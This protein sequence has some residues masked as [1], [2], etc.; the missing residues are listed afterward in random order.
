MFLGPVLGPWVCFDDYLG[1]DKSTFLSCARVQQYVHGGI[2]RGGVEDQV[3]TGSSRLA[4]WG[5]GAPA[6]GRPRA[7]PPVPFARG[8]RYTDRLQL[9]DARRSSQEGLAAEGLH[10][11][12]MYMNISHMCSS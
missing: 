1:G 12:C 7:R 9:Y 2:V 6:D 8:A 5:T 11:M 10:P 3:G 4:R